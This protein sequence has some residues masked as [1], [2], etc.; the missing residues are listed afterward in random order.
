MI[1]FCTLLLFSL[2]GAILPAATLHVGANNPYP[3]LSAAVAVV[4]AGDTIEIH[5]GTYPGGIFFPNLKGTAAQ[6]ITIRGAAGETVVFAGGNNAIQL[7]DPAYLHFKNLIFQ[8]QTG[9]GF[10]TDDGGTYN[11]PAHHI[12]F[13]NCTFRDM[14]VSGNNDLLKLS[15]LDDFEV[16]NCTFLNGAGSGSGIDMVGCHR[17]LIRGN[18]FENMGS[19]AI[20]AKGGTEYI[21]IEGNFFKNCGQRTLN[22]GGSTG[23]Q[24]F[25]PDTAHFEAAN[26]QVYSNIIIGSVAAVAY[27]GSVNVEVVNNTIYLP[28]NWV[29]RILQETVD[30]DRFLECGDNSFHN[31]IVVR[32]AGLS[33]ETNIGPNTRPQTFSFSN[34]LWQHLDNPNWNGPSIP[35]AESNGIINQDPLL[36]NPASGD[37]HIPA[38]SPAV[39]AGLQLLEPVL[40]FYGQDFAVPRSIG[41]AEGMPVSGTTE[42]HASAGFRVYP[43]PFS[44]QFFLDLSLPAEKCRLR[45]YTGQGRLIASGVPETA[46]SGHGRWQAGVYWFVLEDLEQGRMFVQR[47][48]KL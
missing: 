20:Q 8:Q 48:I 47:V 1:R 7:S 13:E 44:W 27:V 32:N 42:Q 11:S 25:R 30:P 23:L 45:V 39:G 35:V 26:L 4:Q 33:T 22:L 15:G 24:F 12:L 2:S 38:N 16:R 14:A 43:N 28:Q 31:N 18:Y 10:N 41:A 9:N 36:N 46:I 17:G 21:R 3:S 34:N 6:W 19:N 40:D 5:A 29:L 37:C